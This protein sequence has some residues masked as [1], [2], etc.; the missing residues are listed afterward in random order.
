[1]KAVIS[2]RIYIEVSNELKE[3]IKKE[4]TYSIPTYGDGPPTIIRN[5]SSFRDNILTI[6][7]GRVD[8]I[9]DDYEIVDKR[10]CAEASFPEF[11]YDLRASQQEIY[12]DLK[13][14]C[15]INAKVGWGKTF[16]A[17]SVAAK[18]GYKTLIV[19]HTIPL[20]HQWAK[21]VEKVFGI[22]PGL[23]GGGKEDYSGPIVIGNVASLTRRMDK[24]CKLFGTVIMDE[25]HHAPSPTFSKVM[26]RSFARYKIGLSG[27]LERKDGL[28]VVLCDYFG[29]K[30][31]KPAKENTVDPVIHAYNTGITFPYGDIWALRV[32]ALKDSEYY[33]DYVVS[34]IKKYEK[35]GHKILV[36]SDRTEFLKIISEKAGTALL[37]GE[38]EDRDEQFRLLDSGEK[39]TISGSISIFKEGISHNPLSCVILA[40]PINNLPMLEQIIGRIQRLAEG[41]LSPVV[42]DLVF[43]GRT[44]ERQFLN[45]VG[46]YMKEGFKIDYL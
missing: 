27:T 26:D 36:V 25:V 14:N 22:K 34:V 30:I 5:F 3:S 21:E 38:T 28:H 45:R 44:T 12:E 1:M 19:V 17:L 39:N 18:L 2:N 9:P 41:K 10:I 23:I 4:L 35:L 29:K 46:F 43:R 8:L 13:D 40:T 20:M 24:L 7:V 11:R 42:V 15:L 32:N 31:Y 33:Q 6:P 16:M 37:I